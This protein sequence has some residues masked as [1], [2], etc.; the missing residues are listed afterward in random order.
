MNAKRA[1]RN[2]K[3]PDSPIPFMG[4]V[5]ALS[6]QCRNMASSSL[7]GTIQ[8]LHQSVPGGE[9]EVMRVGDI[10]YV[11]TRGSV[12]ITVII[13]AEYGATGII[14][15]F[16]IY[17]TLL[18]TIDTKILGYPI[19]A[20]SESF[21]IFT[22]TDHHSASYYSKY[23]YSGTQIFATEFSIGTVNSA[24]GYGHYDVLT[25]WADPDPYKEGGNVQWVALYKDYEFIGEVNFTCTDIH[26]T[27]CSSTAITEKG[28]YLTINDYDVEG[29]DILNYVL[30]YD[31]K[32]ELKSSSVPENGEPL[33]FPF[34]Q[35]VY[36][37]RLFAVYSYDLGGYAMVFDD[38]LGNPFKITIQYQF[39]NPLA[40]WHSPI[41]VIDNTYYYWFRNMAVD[42][43]VTIVSYNLSKGGTKEKI[44]EIS[45]GE[46]TLDPG[47]MASGVIL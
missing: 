19:S 15:I 46:G 36:A 9:V 10:E 31:L 11:T 6:F 21:H 28:V 22:Y 37:S 33:L 24:K 30:F 5:N 35:D 29:G 23:N 43:K 45:A 4:I 27:Q 41:G 17:G 25:G 47:V 26:R 39:D 7:P 42:H 40:I 44:V 13:L 34:A 12:G 18:R 14:K 1:I 16:S 3:G 20:D 32:M 8:K 38:D 2:W